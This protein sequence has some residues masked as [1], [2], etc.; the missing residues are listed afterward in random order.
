MYV[1]DGFT[2]VV[3]EAFK[4]DEQVTANALICD[5]CQAVILR[6]GILKGYGPSYADKHLE[7]HEKMGR[8]AD[9]VSRMETLV[10]LLDVV[11]SSLDSED[12]LD[13]PADW[14]KMDPIQLTRGDDNG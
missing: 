14:E 6:G 8:I 4:G 12:D 5:E 1:P 7:W 11:S 10:A 9:L 3:F 13:V 2:E